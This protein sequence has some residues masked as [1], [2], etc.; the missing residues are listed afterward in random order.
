MIVSK[1]MFAFGLGVLM[2]GLM[3]GYGGF[4]ADG[5]QAS[6]PNGKALFIGLIVFLTGVSMIGT[7]IKN[8]PPYDKD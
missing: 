2:T 3:I 8:Q 1:W 7:S 4:F 6:G 5:S